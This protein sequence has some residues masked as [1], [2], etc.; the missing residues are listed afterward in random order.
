MKRSVF[1]K[2][3]MTELLGP[4]GVP[5]KPFSALDSSSPQALWDYLDSVRRQFG[6]VIAIPHN[7]NLSNGRMFPH[8]ADSDQSTQRFRNEPLVEITQIKGSSETHPVL[9]PDDEW[10]DFEL[11]EELMGVAPVKI[12]LRAGSY[13]RDGL[14]RGLLFQ[15]HTDTNPYRF[16]VVGG[17]DS[18][19]ASSPV[20]ES[21]YSGKIGRGDGSA[22][23]RREGGSI[24][25]SNLL[26]SAA[27]LTGLWAPVNTRE[28]IFSALRRGQTFATSGTRI[29]LRFQASWD[30]VTLAKSIDAGFGNRDA[31]AVPMGGTLKP[32]SSGTSPK[33]H[34]WAARD[35]GSAPLERIQLIKGWLRDG[36]SEERV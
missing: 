5:S 17:S 25:S 7:S 12:G 20:E 1:E 9:S 11:L 35:P 8:F 3:P 19:N 28:A 22:K 36:I 10:A 30:D 14:L 33:F 32:A 26:Y 13:V 34:F 16:G 2:R 29:Q 27:G 15:A 4:E 23:A 31:G 18:H 6:D 21:N 24:T